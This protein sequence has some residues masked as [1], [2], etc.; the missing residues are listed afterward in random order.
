M[1]KWFLGIALLF[2]LLW[3]AESGGVG[4][5]ADLTKFASGNWIGNLL[6]MMASFAFREASTASGRY[7]CKTVLGKLFR[8]KTYECFFSDELSLFR[9]LDFDLSAYEHGILKT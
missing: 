1:L 4:R 3:R 7:S 5:A 6:M 2:D 9:K 8:G